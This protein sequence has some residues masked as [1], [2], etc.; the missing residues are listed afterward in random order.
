MPS[1]VSLLRAALLCL[2]LPAW[3]A[4]PLAAR[5]NGMEI[6]AEQ[7]QAL[8]QQAAK[9]GT[10]LT[11]GAATALLIRRELLAQQALGQGADPQADRDALAR[12]SYQAYAR[13]HPVTE[14][15]TRRE[16]QRLQAENPPTQEYLP[17]FILVKTAAEAKA[18]IAG[19]NDG[20]PFAS[21]VG[22]S[23]DANSRQDGGSLGWTDTSN[24]TPQYAQAI[25]QLQPG[26]HTKA[27]LAEPFGYGVVQ[28]E[29]IRLASLP[30][31]EEMRAQITEQLK[32]QRFE[33]LLAPLRAQAKITVF[34]G[35][36]E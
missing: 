9:R 22:R 32:R 11:P 17:R 6:D 28:L 7:V 18:I 12:Q 5:V 33:Q 8:R 10:A 20:Q 16:Y 31:Y 36:A 35:Y 26:A 25:A 1:I 23:I 2:A 15:D 21:F 13:A 29:A 4:G 14:A 30:P 24:L 34:D 27:P 19:L 3:A